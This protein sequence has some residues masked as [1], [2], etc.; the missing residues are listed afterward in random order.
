MEIE[1]RDIEWYEDYY[2]VS[3]TWLV[4]SLARKVMCKNWRIRNT[5][6]LILKPANRNWM[7]LTVGLYDTDLFRKNICI[8]R[9]VAWLF[10]RPLLDGEVVS[11]I[12]WNCIDNNVNNLLIQ[13]NISESN[14]YL[15]NMNYGKRKEH[16]LHVNLSKGK[17]I[18]QYTLSWK[19]LKSFVSISDAAR[20]IWKENCDSN[21]INAAKWLYKQAYWYIRKYAE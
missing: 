13:S 2:Q 5:K 18:N 6:S 3:N 10:I 14:R 4:K 11:H 21:I 12:N 19:F 16:L 8:S 15:Y 7:W 9:L 17:K 1:R 20:Y